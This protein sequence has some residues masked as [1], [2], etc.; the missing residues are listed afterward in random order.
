MRRAVD[1]A[2][3]GEVYKGKSV[4]TLGGGRGQHLHVLL[5]RKEEEEGGEGVVGLTWGRSEMA[6]HVT[7]TR[8]V[9]CNPCNTLSYSRCNKSRAM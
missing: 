9:T 6:R 4:V 1:A 3:V 5:R 8:H 2:L 7:C